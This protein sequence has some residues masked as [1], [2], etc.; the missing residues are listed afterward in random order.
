M[1]HG[2]QNVKFRSDYIMCHV[3]MIFGDELEMMW[4]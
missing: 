2:Q 1:M 4:T 3:K